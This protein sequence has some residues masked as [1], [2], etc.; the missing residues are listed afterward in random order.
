MP[1]AVLEKEIERLDETQQNTVALFVRFLLSQK[2]AL[3]DFVSSRSRALRRVADENAPQWLDDIS[4][5]ISL[6]P[7]KS[8]DDLVC[9]AIAEK[10]GDIR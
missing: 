4:G 8:D 3:S 6:P 1:F 7:G 5:I 2:D 9:E 10:Y